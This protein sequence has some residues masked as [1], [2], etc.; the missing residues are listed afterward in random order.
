ME[1]NINSLL[2]YGIEAVDGEIGRIEDFYFDDETW[3][4]RYIVVKTGDWLSGRKVLISVKA[5]THTGIKDGLFPLNITQEQIRTSPDINTEKPVSRQQEAMLNKHH[6]WQNYWGSGYYGGEMGIT[7][8]QPLRIKNLDPDPG[9][10][11]HL[12]SI[13]QVSGYAIHATD[14]EI[15]HINDFIVNDQNWTLVELVVDTHNWIGG[16]KVL[17]E[18]THVHSISF[19]SWLVY[20]DIPISAIIDCKLF[21]EAEFNQH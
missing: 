2:G 16:K 10:D 6:F 14:G 20:V 19:L 12:R 8:R 13:L 21:E 18:V 17:I 11:V 7:N 4:I 9:E 3:I 1:H 15:G 5:L